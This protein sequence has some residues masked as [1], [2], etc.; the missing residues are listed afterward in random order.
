MIHTADEEDIIGRIAVEMEGIVVDMRD[1]ERDVTAQKKEDL[2]KEERLTNKNE[3]SKEN[4]TV[5]TEV[6]FL[7]QL[8]YYTNFCPFLYLF[9][10]STVFRVFSAP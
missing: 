8:E 10:F 7:L 9:F 5:D 4:I 2:H 6:C 1:L 3:A